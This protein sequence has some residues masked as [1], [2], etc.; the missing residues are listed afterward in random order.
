MVVI[1]KLNQ[2]DYL[3]Q[4]NS[5]FDNP[6]STRQSFISEAGTYFQYDPVTNP[7]GIINQYDG[8]S[9]FYK[10]PLAMDYWLEQIS[11]YKPK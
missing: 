1:L 11:K 9:T 3:N 5:F 7:F 8:I 2:N 10:P 4:A 6:P